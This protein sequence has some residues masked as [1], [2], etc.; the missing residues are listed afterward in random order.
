MTMYRVVAVITA[1]PG[2]REEL[3]AAFR[4]NVPNVLAEKG[5]MEYAGHIDAADVGPF[6]ARFGPDTLVVLESRASP[7]ASGTTPPR[8]T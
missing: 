1:S 8:R 5:C 3:V 4:A 7:E 6:Q 2:R